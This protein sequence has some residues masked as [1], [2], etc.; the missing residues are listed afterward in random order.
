[1]TEDIISV[2]I[3]KMRTMLITC[4]FSYQP[5]LAGAAGSILGAPPPNVNP[6]KVAAAGAPKVAAGAGVGTPNDAATGAPKVGAALGVP[7][8]PK[9]KAGDIQCEEED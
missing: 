7:V 5:V 9:S 4:H 8:E 6:P 3:S 1:M 2:F